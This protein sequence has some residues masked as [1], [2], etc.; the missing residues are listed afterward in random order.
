MQKNIYDLLYK[1]ELS[2]WWSSAR[3]D[4][5]LNFLMKLGTRMNDRILD[6]GCGTGGMLY[7]LK[8]KGFTHIYG[9]DR[10]L[11]AISYSKRRG[12]TALIV[13]DAAAIPFKKETFDWIILLD[14]LEHLDN[15]VNVLWGLRQ[16]LKPNGRLAITVPAIK[17]LWSARDVRLGHKRRYSLKELKYKL[18]ISG[19]QVEKITYIDLFYFLPMMLIFRLKSLASTK[20]KTDVAYVP[21]VINSVFKKILQIEGKL[22]EKVDL[23]LGVAIFSIAKNI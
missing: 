1:H 8:R 17:Q 2:Y 23:P 9:I 21:T 13:A 10:E 5:V 19:F 6:I 22:I 18:Q 20:V 7:E 3:R 14:V 16:V 4:K 15:D 11:I 12:I